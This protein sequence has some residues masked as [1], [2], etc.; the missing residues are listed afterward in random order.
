MVAVYA[1]CRQMIAW[2][3]TTRLPSG[4]RD[5]SGD[6]AIG[7]A[8]LLVSIAK[9]KDISGASS[10]CAPRPIALALA[11]PDQRFGV[12]GIELL[13]VGRQL[14][15][16]GDLLGRRIPAR[17]R[18]ASLSHLQADRPAPGKPIGQAFRDLF[19]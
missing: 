5:R 8:H 14:V 15:A 17:V 7:L 4:D 12:A 9:P 10:P 18:F 6:V 11:P 2:R 1:A 3:Q 19:Q 16:H 13:E